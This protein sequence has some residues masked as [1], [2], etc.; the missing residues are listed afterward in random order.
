CPLTENLGAAHEA[1]DH[2]RPDGV[3]PGGTD[4]G[5]ALRTALDLFD[6]QEPS[7]GQ[8]V[9]IVSDGE[10]HAHSWEPILAHCRCQRVIM[11]TFAVGDAEQGAVLLQKAYQKEQANSEL[12]IS[13]R[14]DAALRELANSTGGAF[15][16]VGTRSV[17]A[18]ALFKTVIEP[19]TQRMRR[20]LGWT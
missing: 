12:V 1:I 10:D 17:D 18:I 15:V 11:H 3:Q 8:S 13:R 14:D 2:L 16:P 4:L 5:A 20:V 19:G 9:V 7:E 6:D